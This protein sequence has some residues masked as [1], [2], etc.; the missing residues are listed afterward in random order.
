[1][2]SGRSEIEKA[3]ERAKIKAALKAQYIK[4]AY[5]PYRFINGNQPV[6]SFL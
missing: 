1:M 2:A 5:N 6:V 3:A 4:Q